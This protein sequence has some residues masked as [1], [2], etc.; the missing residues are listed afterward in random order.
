MSCFARAR[1][2]ATL[3][4][5][6]FA[7]A[8]APA[9][10]QA[11]Q[12]AKHF[13]AGLEHYEAG[14]FR[15]AA[16]QFFAAFEITPHGDSLYNAGLAWQSAG[17]AGLAATAYERALE[18]GVR[19]E[20]ITDAKSRLTELAPK[21]G[22]VELTAPEGATIHF[23]PFRIQA[24]RTV[25]YFPPGARTVRIVLADGRS[26]E[27]SFEAVAGQTARVEASAPDAP[28]AS[29]PPPA[30]EAEA[31]GPFPWQ[32]VG[33]I[34]IGVGA[35]AA[36]TAVF[37]GLE[38]VDTR[39][40]FNDSGYTDRDKHDEAIRLMHWTNVAWATA[41]ITAGAGVSILLFAPKHESTEVALDVGPGRLGVRGRF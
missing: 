1:R 21:L 25:L 40:E 33:W 2:A 5:V 37:L 29:S 31:Q 27:P 34:A 35:A 32:T 36:T 24:T 6:A 17:E 12:A 15:E 11:D 10:A 9:S 16:A 7:L 39:D 4:A 19:D 26:V 3:L 28:A 22:R 13:D 30:A 8:P 23:A 38:A 14:R 18:L 20:A 41:A